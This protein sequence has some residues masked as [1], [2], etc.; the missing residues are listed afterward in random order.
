MFQ[1]SR[2]WAEQ[3]ADAYFIASAKHLVIEPATV[4][5]PYN[6]AITDLPA[7]EQRW[8]ARQI[9]GQF[10][11]RWVEHCVFDRNADGFKVA[12][13]KP[14]VVLLA[15]QLYLRGF[16]DRILAGRDKYSFEDPLR[17]LG[18][19]DRLAWFKAQTRASVN[20]QLKLF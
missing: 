14:R 16:Y 5:E 12:V 4:I 7:E 10:H 19:G 3:N 11:L 15:S 2:R 17:G 6:L 13:D 18:I 8:R 20:S 9:E 1:A